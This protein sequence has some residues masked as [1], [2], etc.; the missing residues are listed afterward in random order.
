[1]NDDLAAAI[2]RAREAKMCRCGNLFIGSAYDVHRDGD[3]C[4]PAHT[5]ESLLEQ[6]DG[7]WVMRGSDAGP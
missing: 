7:A 3:R 4:L 1:M 6:R 5:F 2:A